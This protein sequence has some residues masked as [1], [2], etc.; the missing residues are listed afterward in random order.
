MRYCVYDYHGK[1][2]DYYEGPGTVSATGKFRAPSGKM[3]KPECIAAALPA[4]CVH[5]G[6]G[7]N[8]QGTI[9]TTDFALGVLDTNGAPK[10]NWFSLAAVAVVA[11][12]AGKRW[13]R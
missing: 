2:F 8:A 6:S 7:E 12:I 9:A 5:V 1:K 13:R 10:T 3:N 4:G 11:F